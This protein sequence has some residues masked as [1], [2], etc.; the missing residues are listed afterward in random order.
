MKMTLAF[1]KGSSAPEKKTRKPKVKTVKPA[2]IGKNFMGLEYLK[3]NGY[4]KSCG[5]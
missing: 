3:A 5:H 2:Q 4:C 1:S